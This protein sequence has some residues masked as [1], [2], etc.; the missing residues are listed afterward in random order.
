MKSR[1]IYQMTPREAWE[2][3]WEQAIGT[4]R[5]VYEEEEHE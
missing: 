5:Y 1:S 3:V 2:A 4:C